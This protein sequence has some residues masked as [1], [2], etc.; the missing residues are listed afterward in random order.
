MSFGTIIILGFVFVIG[1]V[2]VVFLLIRTNA[3]GGDMQERIQAYATVPEYAIERKTT[4]IN[5]RLF[6]IRRQLN[7]CLLYTSPSPRDRQ[8]SRMPSSA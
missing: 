6:R 4:R 2:L 3:S 5:P 8:R 7:S 1:L